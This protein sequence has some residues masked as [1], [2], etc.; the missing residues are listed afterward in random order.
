MH[1]SMRKRL[2]LNKIHTKDSAKRPLCLSITRAVSYIEDTYEQKGASSHLEFTEA[3]AEAAARA[4]ELW[5]L[6]GLLA[7]TPTKLLEIKQQHWKRR[8]RCR[9]FRYPGKEFEKYPIDLLTPSSANYIDSAP[10]DAL[11]AALATK[12]FQLAGQMVEN[13]VS[14]IERSPAFGMPLQI[15]AAKGA[16]EFVRTVLSGCRI[17]DAGENSAAASKI[18]KAPRSV[19]LGAAEAGHLNI[20]QNTLQEHKEDEQNL[21]TGLSPSIYSAVRHDNEAIALLLLQYR[22]PL[23]ERGRVRWTPERIM[24]IELEFWRYL[25]RE[26]TKHNLKEVL[27]VASATVERLTVLSCLKGDGKG[28]TP[29]TV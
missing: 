19:L 14:A 24:R 15:A 28:S 13:G 16:E 6:Y 4:L 17:T 5:D 7:T 20:V 27:K 2:I 22:S 25:V 1:P 21:S 29:V 11:I 10:Q 8:A 12:Q 9:H 23:S 18:A 3:L 26:A